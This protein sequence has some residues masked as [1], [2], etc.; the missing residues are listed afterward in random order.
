MRYIDVPI[1]ILDD[2]LPDLFDLC[3]TL[4]DHCEEPD[5]LR[6]LGIACRAALT[7]PKAVTI[8]FQQKDRRMDPALY[9][10][11]FKNLVAKLGEKNVFG[12]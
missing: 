11:D 2:S 3:K 1:E 5:G 9:D 12:L 6:L 4:T 7:G 8:E 10:H